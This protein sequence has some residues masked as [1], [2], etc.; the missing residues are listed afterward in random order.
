[1]FR[2]FAR[3][4][5]KIQTYLHSQGVRNFGKLFSANV[6]AQI[7]GLIVYPILTRLYAP[8]DFGL[9]NLFLSIGG[10]LTIL[11]TA[12]YQYAIVL[13]KEEK[14]A[15]GVFQVG[16]FILLYVVAV[17]LLTIP[18]SQPIS[19]IFN[20][21]SLAH[22][23]WLMPFFVGISGFWILL[24]YYYTRHKSFGNI[25][26]YQMSQSI[27]NACSKIGCG[28]AGLLHGGL[29]CSTVIAPIIAVII[30]MSRSWRKGL[31][32]WFNIDRDACKDAAREYSNFPKYS[33]PR[34]LVNNL[35]SNLPSLL[36]TPFF[37]LTSL[38]FFGMAITLAFRPLNMISASLYQVLFQHITERVNKK[39]TIAHFFRKFLL[40]TVLIIV[41]CFALLYLILP[42][43]T[44]WLL[45]AE[46]NVTGHYIRVMLPWLTMSMLVAPI[47][48]LSDL[49]RKQKIGLLLEILLVCA[50]LAG[51][52]VGIVTHSFYNAIIGYS[53]CSALIIAVQLVWYISL[54]ARYERSIAAR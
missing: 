4:M 48:F 14:Q 32:E 27:L 41:P 53:L 21:P 54:V 7:I 23:Y 31:R 37:G 36:L 34:A 24:N 40:L 25:S 50:R 2:T 5:A 12:E 1:M 45:G 13:P 46:W 22:W 8:D 29:I 35:S 9:L 10:V 11:A 51:M 28:Y 19:H 38:G 26:R 49:F 52:L 17:L 47:C 39:Q 15:K 30:S 33:T 42:W 20:T 18:F 3:S 6:L 44:S 16:L 43:L